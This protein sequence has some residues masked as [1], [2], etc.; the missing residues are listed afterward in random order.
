MNNLSVYLCFI[1]FSRTLIIFGRIGTKFRGDESH[2]VRSAQTMTAFTEA[3]RKYLVDL[4]IIMRLKTVQ[5]SVPGLCFVS[6][7][8]RVGNSY[9]VWGEM[10]AVVS[11]VFS[12]LYHSVDLVRC[13]IF[14][15]RSFL[16]GFEEQ[17][18]DPSSFIDV[19]RF[20]LGNFHSSS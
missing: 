2:T 4:I 19:I 3:L 6:D 7:G 17:S 8:L 16:V 15:L 11:C 10:E 1:L 13:C 5:D 9:G 12:G 20:V 14:F 18:N